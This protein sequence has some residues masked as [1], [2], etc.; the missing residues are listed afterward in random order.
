MQ[1]AID[2]LELVLLARTD[3]ASAH[4]WKG[5]AHARLGQSES[6]AEHLTRAVTLEPTMQVARLTLAAQ[7]MVLGRHAEAASQ[8]E[9]AAKLQALDAES[10]FYLGLAY[11][12][13]GRSEQ[14]RVA[15]RRALELQ[16][17]HAAAA[18]ALA[19]LTEPG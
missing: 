17:G 5:L 16:P 9:A 18:E 8:I 19:R 4:Y 3:D 6:A 10:Q 15:L 7:L 12:G 13:A 11:E 1:Q 2:D 14:A